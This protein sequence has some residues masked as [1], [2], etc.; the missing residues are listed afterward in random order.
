MHVLVDEVN[1]E[2]VQMS[3]LEVKSFPE[4]G[5][6]NVV[7]TR[8]NIACRCY[9][10]HQKQLRLDIFQTLYVVMFHQHDKAINV[11]TV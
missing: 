7:V 10:F 9:L 3:T 8:F 6:N 2:L 4:L 11:G 1:G 5:E